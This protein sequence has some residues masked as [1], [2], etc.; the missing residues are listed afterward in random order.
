VVLAVAVNGGSDGISPYL[1]ASG[2][3]NTGGGGG[4]S[5]AG[6]GI[7]RFGYSNSEVHKM[8][9]ARETSENQD[10]QRLGATLVVGLMGVSPLDRQR[11]LMLVV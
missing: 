5:S 10:R 4:G 2:T 3:A 9:R 1:G 6:N 7:W 8:T 11:S